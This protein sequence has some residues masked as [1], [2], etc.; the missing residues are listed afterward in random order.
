MPEPIS[1]PPASAPFH[2]GYLPV[3]GTHQ[4][5]FAEYGQSDAPPVVVLHG[6]PASGCKPSML[7]NFDLAQQRV[8][9]FDQRGA[10]KS[11]PHGEIRNNNT[12]KLVSD[13]ERLRRHLGISRWMVVGGSW[14]GTLAIC[15]AGSYPAAIRALVLRGV[16]LASTREVDWFF[17]ALRALVPN[18]WDSLTC[19]WTIAQKR[20][21]FQTLTTKLHSVSPQEQADAARRW[22]EY[23]EAVMRAM[24]GGPSS[25]VGFDVGWINKYRLQAHYLA[26]ACFVSQR[27][28]FRCA[29][30]TVGIPTIMLHGTHDW[31]C[32][33]ENATRL[34]RFMSH[35]DLRW[36]EKGTHTSSDPA[37]CEALRVAIRDL[38]HA[39]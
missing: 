36:I 10:G 34:I 29:R 35:A 32:P 12:W 21:V 16:F 23:E 38:Q 27:T 30:H 11:L 6:G 31:I 20:S 19:G 15:Y 28:L 8:V 33:P 2:D 14:G 1:P 39:Q 37:I 5:Y 25:P 22:G 4:L 26:N 24:M 17:Q 7:Q 3:G 18:G 9:L 13:L